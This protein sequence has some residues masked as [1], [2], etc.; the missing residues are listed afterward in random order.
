MEEVPSQSKVRA[1]RPE[2][3][4]PSLIPSIATA[5]FV[6]LAVVAVLYFGREIFM[7]L[8]LA[9]LLS[10]ALS[11]LV[12]LLRR[13]NVPQLGA[14][15]LAVAAAFV[16][17]GAI[18]SVVARQVGQLAENLPGYQITIGKKVESL[19]DVASGGGVVEKVTH[20]LEGLRQQI[21]KPPAPA[22]SP[23]KPSGSTD[24]EPKPIPVEIQQGPPKPLEIVQSV[25]SPI[26]APLAT[27]GIVVVFA[28]F[29]L[30]YRQDLRDRFIRLV[31]SHDLTRTTAAMNDAA[32]R[33]SRYL[34]TQTAINA[35]FG[36]IVGIGLWLIGIPNPVLWGIVGALMRFVPY[37]GAIIA[38]A[39]PA[40][41]AMAVDPGW[42][43]LA[44]TV[45]LFLIVEAIVGQ[46][47]EPLLYGHHTGLS[48]MAV[49]VAATFW[50]WLWGPIGLLL[51]TP[52]T[53]C[54]VVLGRYVKRLEFL[55][56]MLGDEPAL[57]P[58]EIFYQRMLAGDPHEAAD[59]AE[60]FLKE[61]SL[62]LFYDEVVIPGL[63]MAQADLTEGRLEADKIIQIRD[64]VHEVLDDLSD[65]DDEVPVQKTASKK[66]NK[67]SSTS[68]ETDSESN[69]L[70]A[71]KEE[72]ELAPEWREGTPVLCVGSRSPLDE[73]A[74]TMLAQLL[75]K[76]GIGARCE[77]RE[78]LATARIFQL[79]AV[80][81]RL[82]CL[83][84]LDVSRPV[85]VRYLARRV[86]R[87]LPDALI[88]AGFW[89]PDDETGPNDTTGKD[90]QSSAGADLCAA[91]LRQA[92]DI[93][94]EA[95]RIKDDVSTPADA[96][97]PNDH[98]I[99]KRTGIRDKS[100]ISRSH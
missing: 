6:G 26:L 28:I 91:S 19:R 82:V 66:G 49:V 63:A 88:L 5:L 77:P 14:V 54:L 84:C 69:D 27:T 68:S 29:I 57:A 47:L 94:I 97:I 61:R 56:V 62:S 13:W 38:A 100:Q 92:V 90:L 86:R 83:S 73:A 55:E 7:P 17:I 22:E 44:W 72:Q 85:E 43:M 25:L 42:S 12:E 99:G 36:V 93:C 50:T 80:G 79:E 96:E 34:L 74:A 37:I 23:T 32:S 46:V 15:M 89:R 40:A 67:D 20:A 9:M 30:F 41:L 8:A 95:A 4:A 53:A 24:T 98:G 21:S 3:P 16:V 52:L 58:E 45:A 70:P 39:F 59:Q 1:H 64:A 2:I 51:S 76:H 48:P 75:E 18:G 81:V 11:P 87:K 35:S 65:H 60:Q 33:L 10:F 78:A 71:V 31:G